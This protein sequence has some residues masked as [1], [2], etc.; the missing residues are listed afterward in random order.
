M[1]G[2]GS[3]DISGTRQTLQAKPAKDPRVNPVVA[4]RGQRCSSG[5]LEIG[6][7]PSLPVSDSFA[8]VRGTALPG[9][10]AATLFDLASAARRATG[11]PAGF[12]PVLKR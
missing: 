2:T 11:L 6:S 5:G 7:G 9:H 8:S 10:A 4:R 1:P 12:G 3:P